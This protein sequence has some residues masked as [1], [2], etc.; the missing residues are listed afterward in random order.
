MKQTDMPH[1]YSQVSWRGLNCPEH[2][3]SSGTQCAISGAIIVTSPSSEQHAQQWG[4]STLK[5]PTNLPLKMTRTDSEWTRPVRPHLKAGNV[6][7]VRSY[8]FLPL[9]YF[10][11]KPLSKTMLWRG[12]TGS[13]R[14]AARDRNDKSAASE[15]QRNEKRHL[16]N[17]AREKQPLAR[18]RIG[19]RKKHKRNYP[20][21]QLCC[22]SETG[23]RL[24]ARACWLGL[25]DARR[26]FRVDT[27]QR[28]QSHYLSQIDFSFVLPIL[29]QH[30]GW[31]KNK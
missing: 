13:R 10:T 26:A 28:A 22:L 19:M 12:K 24:R 3:G 31:E 18:P 23:A 20:S 25:P 11:E 15:P 17:E 27:R 1:L 29:V 21:R 8:S 16:S 14:P 7:S 9:N 2:Q 5:V 30:Q 4:S 6:F